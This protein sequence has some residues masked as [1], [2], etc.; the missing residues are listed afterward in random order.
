MSNESVL[1]IIRRVAPA[2]VIHHARKNEDRERVGAGDQ[3]D[4]PQLRHRNVTPSSKHFE[5][6]KRAA[7][8]FTQREHQVIVCRQLGLV[9]VPSPRPQACRGCR[10]FRLG[11]RL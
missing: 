2:R 7:R 5:S 3:H 10:V 4:A 9:F 11:G 6:Q 1:R 8:F